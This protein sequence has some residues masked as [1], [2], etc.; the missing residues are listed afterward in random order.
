ML[1]YIGQAFRFFGEFHLT[2]GQPSLATPCLINALTIFHD[3]EKIR[4]REQARCLAAV[5]AGQELMPR[6]IELI[7][8][9]GKAGKTSGDHVFKL[10]QW[11]DTREL[12]WSEDSTT[13]LPS[14]S[15]VFNIVANIKNIAPKRST[16]TVS[17]EIIIEELLENQTMQV[18]T[19]I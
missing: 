15:Q 4:D 18:R 5:S 7:L 14:T 9:C 12:F 3:L 19:R 16:A 2:E 17:E 11:K 6:Y 8:K 10:V 1:Y 13:S